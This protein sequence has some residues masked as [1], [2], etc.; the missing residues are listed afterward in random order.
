MLCSDIVTY[1]R[2]LPTYVTMRPHH[3]RPIGAESSFTMSTHLPHSSINLS[4][5]NVVS[6]EVSRRIIPCGSPSD[7]YDPTFEAFDIV[8]RDAH[9][10]VHRVNMFGLANLE[11]RERCTPIKLTVKEEPIPV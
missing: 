11:T 10:I 8:I 3:Q 7:Q 6:C 4:I 9:G 2:S 5:H 1:L